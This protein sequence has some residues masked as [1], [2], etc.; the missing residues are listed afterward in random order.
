MTPY[1]PESGEIIDQVCSRWPRLVSVVLGK[2]GF[3]I[4]ML[5]SAG[6]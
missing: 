5:G 3:T 2:L 1:S 4:T 6:A